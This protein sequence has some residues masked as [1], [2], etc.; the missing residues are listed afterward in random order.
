MTPY[1][2]SGMPQPPMHSA[3][4]AMNPGRLPGYMP[5][6]PPPSLPPSSTV[7]GIAPNV[8]PPYMATRHPGVSSA[9]QNINTVSY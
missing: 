3:Y 9:T 8:P 1:P 6:V 4:N 5:Q 7:G 2:A